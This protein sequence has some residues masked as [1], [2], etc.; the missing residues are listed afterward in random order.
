[1]Q[2]MITSVVV[3]V[4]LGASLFGRPS[5]GL[6]EVGK[7]A[8]LEKATGADVAACL[9]AGADPR[10]PGKS[11]ITPLHWAAKHSPNPAMVQALITAGASLE[12]RGEWKNTPLHTAAR[13]NE[14]AEIIRVLVE[15]GASLRRGTSR[16]TH[17]FTGRPRPTRI[18][19]SSRRCGGRGQP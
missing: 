14:N 8:L 5:C 6:H 9:N 2:R 17:L 7:R 11:K 10:R 15:A 12:A 3:S 16:K 19:R 4:L 13:F 18:R 1:M